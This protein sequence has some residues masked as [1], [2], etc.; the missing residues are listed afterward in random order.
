MIQKS[1][2]TVIIN[3]ETLRSNIDHL[4]TFLHEDTQI[5]AVVKADAYGHGAVRIA[6][7]IEADV[8]GF[9]VNDIK[10][11]IELR[12]NGIT[13]P[14]LVFGVPEQSVA[15]QYRIHNLTATVG[16]KKHFNWLPAGTSYHL[17]FDTGMGR[18]GFPADK[19]Q[20][21]SELVQE[22]DD[23]I[24]TGIYS[25]FATSGNPGSGQVEQQEKQF[26]EIRSY[27]PDDLITHIANTGGVAFY[28]IEPFSRVRIGIGMYGYPPADTAIDGINPVLQWKSRLIQLKSIVAGST[29]SYGAHWS[30]PGKG[31]VGV[32]PVGYEDGLRRK[33]SGQFSVLIDEKTYELVGDITMNYCMVHL[34]NDRYDIGQ[35]VKLLYEGNDARDWAQKL[36]TIPYEILTSIHPGIRRVYIS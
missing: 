28:D 18:L 9:A 35:E 4:K 17:N 36:G 25:H 20:E 34:G 21:V 12:E 26:R 8:A 22:H 14:V 3:L 16:D 6:E 2:A 24:C 11:G 29:V 19:V 7:S 30:A 31:M 1:N 33:L 15:G 5:M 13:K 23:L 27:F 10:E 32:I